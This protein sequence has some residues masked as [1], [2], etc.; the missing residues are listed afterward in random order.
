MR[1]DPLLILTK[2]KLRRKYGRKFSVQC[3]IASINLGKR[4]LYAL[5]QEENWS[6]L[7]VCG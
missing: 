3:V 1:N 5:L 7:R 6:A 4:P 2:F